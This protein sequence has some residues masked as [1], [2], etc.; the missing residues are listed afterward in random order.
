MAPCVSASGI[1]RRSM[2][3]S[4][5]RAKGIVTFR[6]CELRSLLPMKMSQIPLGQV[7]GT[8]SKE[9]SRTRTKGRRSSRAILHLLRRNEAE[10]Q[11]L[12]PANL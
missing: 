7:K 5:K 12:R 9:R 11:V 6:T 1:R 10:Q 8:S 2:P 3:W 4:K